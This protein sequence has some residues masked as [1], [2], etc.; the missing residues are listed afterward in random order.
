MFSVEGEG[1]IGMKPRIL[2]FFVNRKENYGNGHEGK[3]ARRI[4]I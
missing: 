1:D 3:T 4:L 2:S